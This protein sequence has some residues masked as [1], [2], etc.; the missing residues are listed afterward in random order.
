[1]N[2]KKELATLED[3]P[4]EIFLHEIF[5]LFSLK[6]LC[7]SF[8]DLNKRISTI[9]Q[10]VQHLDYVVNSSTQHSRELVVLAQCFARLT[11][12]LGQ[13]DI[14]PFSA[15]RSLTLQYPSLQQRC[16]IRP[17]NFPLL[18]YLSLSYPLND[19]DL[20]NSIFSNEFKRLKKCKFDTIHVDHR[21]EGSPNIR[22]LS[23]TVHDS[24]GIVC[25]FRAC[26]NIRWLNIIVLE[27]VQSGLLLPKHPIICNNLALEHLFIRS[28][29]EMLI[30]I[31]KLTPNLKWL[32]FDDIERRRVSVKSSSG[33]KTLAKSLST[34]RALSDVYINIIIG[35]WD[36]NVDLRT[37]HPLFK[38]YSTEYSKIVHISSSII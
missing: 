6:E 35:D 8:A 10:S 29:F 17:T 14:A 12:C 20:L 37:F 4:D 25:V 36:I 18:E 22:S 24:Y 15:I 1:M 16:C 30:S 33:L 27:E 19:A 28:T 31:L 23:V 34:L 5:P 21:L 7:Y 38:Y 11:V 13:F 3:L 2:N 32:S 9:I 26:P